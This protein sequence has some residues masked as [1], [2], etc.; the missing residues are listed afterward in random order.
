MQMID[1]RSN[2]KRQEYEANEITITSKVMNKISGCLLDS[3]GVLAS[4]YVNDKYKEQR[5]VVRI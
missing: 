2:A 1:I 3:R 5:K 4:M